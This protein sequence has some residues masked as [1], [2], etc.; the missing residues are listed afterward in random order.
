MSPGFPGTDPRQ[1]PL[2]VPTQVTTLTNKFITQVSASTAH[3]IVMTAE[4]QLWAF[5]YNNYGQLGIGSTT[6]SNEFV[7]ATS[8][9]FRGAFTKVYAGELRTY[10]V[11]TT[12]DCFGW[13]YNPRK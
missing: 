5:G 3:F 10:A 6:S 2:T 13:G 12:G 11:T 7:Q 4:N 9:G 8:K 1:N